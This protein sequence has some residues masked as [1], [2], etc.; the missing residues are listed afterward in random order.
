MSTPRVLLALTADVRM[1]ARAR[2]QIRALQEAGMHVTVLGL[3]TENSFPLPEAIHWIPSH[4][5]SRSGPTFFLT[6]HRKLSEH[7]AQLPAAD[8]YHASDLYVL[9]ALAHVAKHHGARLVYDA[10]ERYPYVAGT[11]GKPLVQRF[12]YYLER[13]YIHQADLVCTVS[14]GLARALR[15]DY[16]IPLPL[17][18]PNVP[19]YRKV[20]PTTHIRKHLQLPSYTPILLHQ[21]VMKSGRG[22]HLLMDAMRDLPEAVLVFMGHGPLQKLLER[23]VALLGL[24]QRVFFLPPVPPDEL[25]SWTASADVGITLLEDVCEN[26]RLALPNK[27]FEYLMAGLPVVA[28]ALPEMERFIQTYGVGRTVDPANRETLVNTL[29]QMVTDIRLRETIKAAIPRVWED[30]RW[31]HHVRRFIEAYKELL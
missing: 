28:S 10:R 14:A 3:K 6:W 20:S 19:E 24:Q 1:N 27:V 12:W 29:R 2:K 17:L 5:P 25:L 22:C 21:G 15:Q 30:Y 4:I 23:Q 7:L 26:H 31:E 8:I 9:P 11:A 16:G 18:L 13:H